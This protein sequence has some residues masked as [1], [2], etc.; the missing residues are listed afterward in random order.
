MY[1]AH[2]DPL[3]G[4]AVRGEK[5]FSFLDPQ[6]DQVVDVEKTSVTKITGRAAPKSQTIVLTID[7]R[8]EFFQ[9]G[10]DPRN[11]IVNGG[12]YP[13]SSEQTRLS[14]WRKISCAL[15]AP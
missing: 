11:F 6:P 7:E 2:A 9:I 10:V 12:D 13:R 3:Q 15:W 1:P 8:G 14:S 4:Q 5:H